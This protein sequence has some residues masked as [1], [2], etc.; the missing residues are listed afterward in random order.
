MTQPRPD[1]DPSVLH[2]YWAL[3]TAD[4]SDRTAVRD[5]PTADEAQE[6]GGRATRREDWPSVRLAVMAGLLRAKFTQH[7]ELAEILLATGDARIAYTGCT[8]SPYWRNARDDRGRNWTGRLLELT[9]AELLAA[10]V[11][12][13][14]GE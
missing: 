5:A 11:S 14:T 3:S 1:P 2:G 7:P 8:E 9:R 13:P 12:W 10:R 4:A 6:R